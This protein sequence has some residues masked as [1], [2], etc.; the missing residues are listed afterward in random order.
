MHT[1]IIH[2]STE[3]YRSNEKVEIIKRLIFGKYQK[4]RRV[5]VLWHLQRSENGN[6][7]KFYL[8]CQMLQMK[9]GMYINT[10]IVLHTEIYKY[11]FLYIF[12]LQNNIKH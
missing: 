10:H 2:R 9:E 6:I 8:S 1:I 7:L 3:S 11:V 12:A 4:Y 5:V